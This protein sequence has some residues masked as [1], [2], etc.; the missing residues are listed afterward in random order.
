MKYL[1]PT[2]FIKFLNCQHHVK[3]LK[4]DKVLG[5]EVDGQTMAMATGTAFDILVKS[6]LNRRFKLTELLDQKIKKENKAAIQVATEL[7]EAYKEGPVSC[8]KDEGIGYGGIDQETEI[9]YNYCKTCGGHCKLTSDR[10]FYID[11]NGDAINTEKERAIGFTHDVRQYKSVLYGMPDLT[12]TDGTVLDWKVSGA[13]SSK[14]A[15]PRPG[16]S[17]CWVY[18]VGNVFHG[19]DQGDDCSHLSLEVVNRDWAIQIYLYARLLGHTPGRQLRGGVENVCVS[20]DNTIYCASYRNTITPEFQR[21]IELKF[22]KAFAALS[23]GT[24]ENPIY[25]E[26]RCKQYNKV[27][28]VADYCSA[29]KSAIKGVP[30]PQCNG[31]TLLNL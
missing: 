4:V 3:L 17:R 11:D 29:Y 30:S 6:A 31:T 13:F 1:S 2:T 24:V 22:H 16:Y 21:E 18:G 27:C 26:Y 20:K 25:G 10:Q 15:T 12:L 14:G 5:E 23:N 8:L 19:K 28:N 7:W 9:E